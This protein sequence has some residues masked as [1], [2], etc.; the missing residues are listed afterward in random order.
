MKNPMM[1]N[2]V[3]PG[4]IVQVEPEYEMK[5]EELESGEF[6][7]VSNPIQKEY[8]VTNFRDLDIQTVIDAGLFDKLALGKPVSV[9]L[10]A[11][12]DAIYD[13]AEFIARMDLDDQVAKRREELDQ[14][15]REMMES[16]Q[17][18]SSSNLDS[19]KQVNPAK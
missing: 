1:F 9:G 19:S 17:Q 3:D 2:S 6:V 16:S 8:P 4:Y 14:Q 13:G 7:T 10:L 11:K 5:T 18:S 15:F 12:Q